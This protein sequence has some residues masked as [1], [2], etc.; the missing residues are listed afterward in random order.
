MVAL[1]KRNK[2]VALAAV[3]V[4]EVEAV[5]TSKVLLRKNRKSF[6]QKM[7]QQ[8]MQDRLKDDCCDEEAREKFKASTDSSSE[9]GYMKFA[10]QRPSVE[11]S[12][13]KCASGKVSHPKC[14]G[15]TLTG[16]NAYVG[17]KCYTEKE[18]SKQTY[19]VCMAA[20]DAESTSTASTMFRERVPCG[21]RSEH[22]LDVSA[23]EK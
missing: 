3:A 1:F 13:A 7:Q 6:L 12:K 14:T 19:Y 9:E 21:C 22:E 20:K 8:R 11:G 17:S 2:F 18:G 5:Q 16:G 10:V 4:T 15:Y 23:P